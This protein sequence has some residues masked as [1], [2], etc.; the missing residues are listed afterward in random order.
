MPILR[1]GG[2]AAAGAARGMVGFDQGSA[3]YRQRAARRRQLEE[4]RQLQLLNGMQGLQRQQAF[5]E[6]TDRQF[7]FQEQ[8]A[9]RQASAD[10]RNFDLAQQQQDLRQQ[11]QDRLDA[12]MYG[13]G[14][15]GGV[16]PISG[17]GV[18]ELLSRMER[19]APGEGA[20]S[21][22]QWFGTHTGG[23]FDVANPNW[24]LLDD[25]RFTLDAYQFATRELGNLVDAQRRQAVASGAE[26]LGVT[27]E[28]MFPEYARSVAGQNALM[29]GQA[30]IQALEAAQGRTGQPLTSAQIRAQAETIRLGLMAEARTESTRMRRKDD[31]DALL[32]EHGAGIGEFDPRY[33]R[34]LKLQDQMGSTS[35]PDSVFDDFYNLVHPDGRR[36]AA[37]VRQQVE[38]EVNAKRAVED[39]RT[40]PTG[41]AGVIAN[42]AT[43]AESEPLPVNAGSGT[44]VK[45]S[46]VP[47]LHRALNPLESSNDFLRDVARRAGVD[48]KDPAAIRQAAYEWLDS[49]FPVDLETPEGLEY[50]QQ[51]LDQ[52]LD[53]SS[54]DRAAMAALIR[55]RL[56]E[57]SQND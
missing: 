29:M 23:E 40:Q 33:E 6:R 50:A 53:E 1:L 49:Q 54:P 56:S 46:Q 45:A 17:G 16:A 38:A 57:A 27:V 41:R 18:R 25:P 48:T 22:L 10:A 19:T 32:R 13:R 37:R 7:R 55:L 26:S 12:E 43:G 15:P 28:R 42:P 24:D 51:L 9:N 44:K 8:Q 2:G 52:G 3:E 5:E 31:M 20:A 34:L 36:R 39:V 35:D 11:Q 4:Q 30:A 14:T 21:F 47:N